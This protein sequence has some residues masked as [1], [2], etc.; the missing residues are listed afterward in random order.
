M[1]DWREQNQQLAEAGVVLDEEGRPD[2]FQVG[3]EAAL[4]DWLFQR[5]V[6]EFEALEKRLRQRQHE[7]RWRAE[8]PERWREVQAKSRAKRRSDPETRAKELAAS[9]AR[10][11]RRRREARAGA[12][13]TCAVCGKHWAPK[14]LHKTDYCSVKCRDRAKYLRR[15]ARQ[16]APPA[17]PVKEAPPRKPVV[18]TFCGAEYQ[19][20]RVNRVNYCSESCRNKACYRRR[21]AGAK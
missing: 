12:V 13:W 14:S 1:T 17:R 20:K 10:G 21:K 15:K 4:S 5:E 18:C 11:R 16:P 2:G 6:A 3:R 8:N 7:Q 19:P 9:A